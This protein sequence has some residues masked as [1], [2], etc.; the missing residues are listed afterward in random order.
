MDKN[1]HQRANTNVTE[2]RTV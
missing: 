1:P 2:N